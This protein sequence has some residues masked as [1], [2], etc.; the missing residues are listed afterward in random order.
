MIRFWLQLLFRNLTTNCEI[1][2]I[3]NRLDAGSPLPSSA[4][5]GSQTRFRSIN[6]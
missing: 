3:C 2:R 6:G 4:R 1:L 5:V